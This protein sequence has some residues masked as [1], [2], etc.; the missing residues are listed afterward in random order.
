MVVSATRGDPRSAEELPVSVTV[1][2]REEIEAS[3]GLTIDEIL[4]TTPGIQLQLTNSN[5]ILPIIPSISMRGLG[6]GD[7][8]TR[9]LVLVDGLPANGAFFGNVFWNRVPKQNVERIEIVR[10]SGSAQFGN[11]ALGGVVNIITRR[12]P[13]QPQAQGEVGYGMQETFQANVYG[14]SPVTDALRLSLNANYYDSDG[15]FEV[16]PEVRGP[17]DRKTRADTLSIQGK[18]EYAPMERVD[19]YLRGNYY[20]QDHQ[21]DTKLSDSHTDIWDIATGGKVALGQFGA[22][23][24]DF[25]YA[26]E[27]FANN[28]TSTIPPDSR[29]AEFISNAHDTPS[30]N[31]GGS[32]RWTRAYGRYVPNT[33]LGMDLRLLRGEDD[34]DIFLADGSLAL[35][36]IG[37]GK[38][39]SVGLFGEASVFPLPQFEILGSLRGDF[40]RNFDGRTTENSAVTNFPDKTFNEVTFRLALRYKLIDAVAVRGAAYRGFRAPTLANLYRSFG[41]TSFVGLSNPLLDP[42]TLIGGEVGLDLHV[43]AAKLTIQLNGFYNTVNN[44]IAGVAV[45]FDPTFTT[46]NQNVGTI[47]SR[48]MELIGTIGPF[49]H[50]SLNFGYTYTDAQVTENRDDPT[51]EGNRVEGAPVHIVTFSATYHRPRGLQLTLRGRYL[52]EQFQDTSNETRLPAHVVIDASASY[53]VIKNLTVFLQVTNLFDEDYTVD[54]FGGLNLRGA[55]RQVFGG[56]RVALP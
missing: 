12:L 16:P 10:G 39:R 46:E 14:G 21:R 15:Y 45:A 8:G 7:N 18:A 35:K 1:I 2:S 51:L 24:A 6:L 23:F 54:A 41:T 34:A 27:R 19:L 33:T 50:V 4:R 20:T 47:R 5:T 49:S 56:V 43:K 48:G 32:L 17:I 9:T 44:F 3:P 38:Q 42:E 11:Y 29:Q 55:P 53:P 37:E 30:T 25:F 28:N 26:D 36:R 52:S 31:I 40:F 22:I 13:D